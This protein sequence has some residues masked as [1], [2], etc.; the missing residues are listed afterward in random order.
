MIFRITFHCMYNR[1]KYGCANIITSI[2]YERRPRQGY[3]M[4]KV[5]Y[6]QTIVHSRQSFLS[7]FS[8][9]DGMA[10]KN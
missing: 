7:A 1:A 8:S 2:E 4:S 6:V 5:Q 10:R 9:N 3:L